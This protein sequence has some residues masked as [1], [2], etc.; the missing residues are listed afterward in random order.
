MLFPRTSNKKVSHI[1]GESAAELAI[2]FEA[3]LLSVRQLA[4]SLNA[5]STHP[6]SSRLARRRQAARPGQRHGRIGIGAACENAKGSEGSYV[7]AASRVR[8]ERWRQGSG[9]RRVCTSQLWCSWIAGQSVQLP[10]C[11]EGLT[12]TGP[13]SRLLSSNLFEYRAGSASPL[14]AIGK[15][16]IFCVYLRCLTLKAA[17]DITLR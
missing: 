7:R 1:D 3:S 10:T 8:A 12:S 2:N 16:G 4:V 13:M 14:L 5:A 11:G 17:E 6:A 9:S 15:V